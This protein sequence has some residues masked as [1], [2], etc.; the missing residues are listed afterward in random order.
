MTIQVS[1][2]T[3]CS[4]IRLLQQMF[5]K[6]LITLIV[7]MIVRVYNGSKPDYLSIRKRYISIKL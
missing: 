1:D 6:I 7:S 3:T 2:F 5:K 4:E